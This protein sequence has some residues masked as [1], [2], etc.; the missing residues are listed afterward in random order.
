MKILEIK[1]IEVTKGGMLR[2]DGERR[3]IHIHVRGYDESQ[4]I[5]NSTLW[6][7]FDS[8]YEKYLCA[9]RCDS[10]VVTFLIPIMKKNYDV[11]RSS[12][13]MSKKLWYD[14]T[15][16]VIP[17][18]SA[19]GKGLYSQVKLD[20]PLTD[21]TYH[22]R[23]V[24]TGMSRG[25]DSFATFYEYGKDFPIPEM[26]INQLCYFNVG[27]HH[28][29]GVEDR[30]QHERYLGQLAGTK[31]FAK[32]VGMP[33]LDVDS[34]VREFIVKIARDKFYPTHT[35]RNLGV[36]LLFQ[37]L[38]RC[39]YYSAA[40]NITDF[41]SDLA[42]DSSHYEKWLIPYLCTESTVF[43]SSGQN[44]SRI[45]KVRFLT[46]HTECRNSLLVC[47]SEDKNCGK[48]E[49][50]RR[51]LMELDALGGDRLN[52]F[53]GAFDLEEYYKND[54]QKW[55]DEIDR[56]MEGGHVPEAYRDTFCEALINR[57]ELLKNS[58]KLKYFSVPRAVC[59][60]AETAYIREKPS[61]DSRVIVKAA[62]GERFEADEKALGWYR[63][64]LQ[65]GG[66]GWISGK[67]AELQKE[68]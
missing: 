65:G 55:F 6:Y 8:S 46:E 59:I 32:Q 1:K 67:K 52:R 62:R 31:E 21:E 15:Y 60:T 18:L 35:Y 9:D 16:H 13:P 19:A 28:G 41:S 56:F 51:T 45:E 29:Q 48:C 68:K 3:R 54:R 61:A 22:G 50:C 43:R 47:F 38:F 26:R 11:V 23:A 20:V 2:L 25:V 4:T 63:V 58:G 53:A 30:S 24:G 27:A 37:K 39:Y 36:V 5:F 12:Y 33:L 14:L 66:F 44:W 57:P 7:E 10:T 49:K 42:D 64:K 40:Y 34:N 17:Q